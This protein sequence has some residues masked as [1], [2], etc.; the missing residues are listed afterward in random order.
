MSSAQRRKA[1]T[2]KQTAWL[3][4]YNTTP[5]EGRASA[6]T[7]NDPKDFEK[8]SAQVRD[9]AARTVNRQRSMGADLNGAVIAERL[10][11][12][13]QARLAERSNRLRSVSGPIAPAKRATGQ[14]ARK[15]RLAAVG[16]G[17]AKTS[18]RMQ[19][20]TKARTDLMRARS[21]AR[22]FIDANRR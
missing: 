11:A 14:A 18:K 21:Q 13:H 8:I 4:H 10:E 15:K 2:G 7:Y 17:P 5:G 22:A 20:I 1:A 6:L 12:R 9:V 3:A 19:S 16:I